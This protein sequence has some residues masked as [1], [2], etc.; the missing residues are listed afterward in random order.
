M[1]T[2]LNESELRDW[3]AF[4]RAHHAVIGKLSAELEREHRMSLPY[5]EVLLMLSRAPEHRMRMSQ[6]AV[7]VMLSPSGLTR[8]IDRMVR[9]G[10]VGREPCESDARVM[11]AVLRPE[12]L[13]AFRDAARTHVRGIRQHYIDRLGQTDRRALRRSLD[14]ITRRD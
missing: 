14:A 6:L 5:Y 12:G 10:R 4:I 13:K 2:R 9:D 8:L 3:W 11:Y 7:A 1:S